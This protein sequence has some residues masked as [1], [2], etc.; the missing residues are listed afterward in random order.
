[1]Y[2]LA[3]SSKNLRIPCLAHGKV[4]SMHVNAR[5]LYH[6]RGSHQIPGLYASRVSEGT[7]QRIA[8]WWRTFSQW[9]SDKSHLRLKHEIYFEC[10]P[11]TKCLDAAA[12]H[13]HMAFCGSQRWLLRKARVMKAFLLSSPVLNLLASVRK[14]HIPHEHCFTHMKRIHKNQKHIKIT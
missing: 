4:V 11:G 3:Q 5:Y 6:L 9:N 2:F 7:H 13:L 12:C 8:S 1:M 10:L 14:L